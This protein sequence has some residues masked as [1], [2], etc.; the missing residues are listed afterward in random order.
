MSM[1]LAS[2][3]Q[4]VKVQVGEAGAWTLT[5]DGE[6]VRGGAGVGPAALI[7]PAAP[8]NM[9]V[10]YRLDT[11]SGPVT[12]TVT[13]QASGHMLTSLNGLERSEFTW[14]G[15]GSMGYTSRGHVTE[16]PGREYPVV[17]MQPRG[18][19]GTVEVTAKTAGA[20][21]MALRDLILTNRPL[22]L[23]HDHAKCAV[24]ECDIPAVQTVIVT[25]GTVKT[26][27]NGQVNIAARIWALELQP[28]G[29]LGINSRVG[30]GTWQ[31]LETQNFTWVELENM[32]LPWTDVEAGVWIND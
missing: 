22:L 23:F 11:P 6:P 7:D 12:A 16:V 17:R 2:S 27:R 14:L 29:L 15:E 31:Q 21:T 1:I 19:I 4:G 18:G 9:P 5:R 32:A 28:T 25:P 13:R 26:A 20:Q 3:M 30:V 24:P 8:L 10:T